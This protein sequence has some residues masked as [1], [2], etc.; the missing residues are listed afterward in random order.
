VPGRAFGAHNWIIGLWKIFVNWGSSG[1]GRRLTQINAY[2]G[3]YPILRWEGVTEIELE[4]GKREMSAKA[5]LSPFP[6]CG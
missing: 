4:Q 1:F 3:K 6:L 2:C 5:D